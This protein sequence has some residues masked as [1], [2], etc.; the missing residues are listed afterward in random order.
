M[1]DSSLWQPNLSFA[2]WY[3]LVQD[4]HPDDGL[5]MG[6]VT[7]AVPLVYLLPLLGI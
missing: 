6:H 7:S 1:D 4:G 3:R 5:S 2:E